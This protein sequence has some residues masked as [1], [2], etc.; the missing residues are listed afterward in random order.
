[1]LFERIYGQTYAPFASLPGP[2]PQFPHGNAL[3]FIF[4]DDRP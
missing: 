2:N 1:M 4:R 3:D